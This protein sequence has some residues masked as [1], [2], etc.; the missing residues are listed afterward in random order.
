MHGRSHLVLYD[1]AIL[2]KECSPEQLVTISDK[3]MRK[4]RWEMC[5]V[6][7]FHFHVGL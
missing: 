5:Y 7:H 1:I 2:L 3:Y 4:R 6:V